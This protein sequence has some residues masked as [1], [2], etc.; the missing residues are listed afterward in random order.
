MT[1]VAKVTKEP[2][3]DKDLNRVIAAN[4]AGAIRRLETPFG[5][6]ETLQAYNHYLGDPDRITWDLD[7][8]R[9][10]TAEKVRATAAKYLTPDHVVIVTTNPS[11]GGAK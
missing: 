1:E 9:K 7:R 11:K 8:Y 4:E 2:L 3:T 6:A 5:R 10:T